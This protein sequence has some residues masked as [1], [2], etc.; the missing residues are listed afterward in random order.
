M[1]TKVFEAGVHYRHDCCVKQ[2]SF[3][4]VHWIANGEKLNSMLDMEIRAYPQKFDSEGTASA[5]ITQWNVTPGELRALAKKM[6]AAADSLEAHEAQLAGR[7]NGDQE[8]M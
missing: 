1:N 4:H 5:S 8:G 7:V 2:V 3:R 6:L